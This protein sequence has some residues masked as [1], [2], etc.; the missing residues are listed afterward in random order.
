MMHVEPTKRLGYRVD[1]LASM[2]GVCRRTIERRIADGTL[3]ATTKLGGT[4][5]SA[6]SVDALLNS[7]KTRKRAQR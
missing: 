3:T 2:L 6:A 4:I 7:S 5:V 1:E